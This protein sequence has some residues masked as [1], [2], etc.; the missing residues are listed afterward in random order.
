M[1]ID[2]FM[3]IISTSEQLLY[4]TFHQFFDSYHFHHGI[5]VLTQLP[6]LC[7]VTTGVFLA[8]KSFHVILDSTNQSV[9]RDVVWTNQS[10]K[11]GDSP[12]VTQETS[13][14]T[15]H[16]WLF[17]RVCE[18]FLIG[19]RKSFLLRGFVG[20]FQ[21]STVTQSE[22]SLYF[23]NSRGVVEDQDFL[24][25]LEVTRSKY[26]IVWITFTVSPFKF[27]LK[28]KVRPP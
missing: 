20:T 14:E 10:W 27:L 19:R 3:K 4:C 22:T 9:L 24:T 21:L 12:G 26:S 28:S 8:T 13:L 2:R 7:S 11:C 23:Q 15:G 25:F 5:N 17:L 16:F 18:G 6:K 1:Y